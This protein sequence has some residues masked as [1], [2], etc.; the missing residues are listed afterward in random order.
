M[1]ELFVAICQCTSRINRLHYKLYFR[2]LMIQ[3]PPDFCSNPFTEIE[4]I[5]YVAIWCVDFVL[6]DMYRHLVT[7]F[8][9]FSFE[10]LQ[11][12]YSF[13]VRVEN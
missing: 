10:L 9:Q 2:L 12:L 8:N 13:L 1:T 4:S 6:Q 7:R 11:H 5:F 3:N